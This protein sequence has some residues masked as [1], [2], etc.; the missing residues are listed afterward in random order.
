M[1]VLFGMI[2]G[3]SNKTPILL[4]LYR[5]RSFIF[6]LY[7]RSAVSLLQLD[8]SLN[9]IDN[10]IDFVLAQ[11]RDVAL[12]RQGMEGLDDNFAFAH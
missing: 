7:V 3:L 8:L 11:F 2:I 4:W 12:G 6:L 1:I 9:L 5:I 10:L